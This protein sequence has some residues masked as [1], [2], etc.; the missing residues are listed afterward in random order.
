MEILVKR[1]YDNGKATVSA[2]YINNKLQCWGLEDEFRDINKKVKGETRVPEG[3]YDVVFR[4]EGG[5]HTRYS[6]MFGANHHGMLHIINVPNFQFILIHVG[7]TEADT[8]GC[9]LVGDSANSNCTVSASTQAY[10]KF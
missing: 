7:N 10:Q 3:E 8:A 4:K 9:L 5:H 1:L 6:K 2:I